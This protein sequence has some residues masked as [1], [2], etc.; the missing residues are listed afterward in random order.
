[1]VPRTTREQRN[2]EL[3]HEEEGRSFVPS[4]CRQRQRKYTNHQ[5]ESFTPFAPTRAHEC[6]ALAH[7]PRRR[8]QPK[9]CV[10][11]TVAR[12][13]LQPFCA[14]VIVGD[15]SAPVSGRGS[16]PYDSNIRICMGC[17]CAALVTRRASLPTSEPKYHYYCFGAYLRP[18][19][20]PQRV[21]R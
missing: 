14:V 17:V 15:L 19:D 1:M 3:Q 6:A 2:A 21:E 9:I 5:T 11:L 8:Q 13:R 12:L 4:D 10:A 7:L 18:E 16:R 20:E